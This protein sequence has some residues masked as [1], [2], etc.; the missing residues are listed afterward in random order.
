MHPGCPHSVSQFSVLQSVNPGV[1][2]SGLFFEKVTGEWHVCKITI[3]VLKEVL[4]RYGGLSK[5]SFFRSWG[6]AD[7]IVSGLNNANQLQNTGIKSVKRKLILAAAFVSVFSSSI[8]PARQVI[9]G[10]DKKMDTKQAITERSFGDIGF[11]LDRITS[12]E[13]DYLKLPNAWAETYGSE[14]YKNLK[15]DRKIAELVRLRVSQLD[16]CNYCEIFHSKGA[17]DAGIPQAK[18]FAL[19]SWRQSDLFTAKEKAA[20]FYAESLSS[21]DQSNIQKAFDELNA[22]K[23]SNAEK[24]E[25]T[26]CVILMNVWSRVFLA[27]GKISVLKDK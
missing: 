9:N 23:Y 6:N 22:N 10:Q 5:K 7:G 17:L 20:I 8:V 21:L 18:I 1:P 27:Q 14:S 19:A 15:I 26:N 13:T 24:E 11:R 16:G 4:H 2:D 3:F 12:N 25:L